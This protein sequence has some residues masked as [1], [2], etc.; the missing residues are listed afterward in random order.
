MS[1]DND[2]KRDLAEIAAHKLRE[3]RITKRGFLQAMAALGVIPMAGLGGRAMAAPSEL[4]I[5]NWGGTAADVIKEVLGDTYKE[6]TGID[7]VIDG[8]GPSAGRIRAMV[9]S[10]AVVWDVCDSG[11]GSAIILG[12][13]GVTEPMNYDIID[14]TKMMEGTDWE[15]G[16]GNY[17]YSYVLAYNP[18][19]SEGG[20]PTSWA[21]VFDTKNFPGMRTFR[22]AVRGMLECATMAQG[23]PLAEVYDVLSTEDGIDAAIEQFRKIRENVIVWGSGSESQNLFL[24]EEVVMGNI[25][26]TR[27][28][29]LK[30]EMDEGTFAVS[31]DGGV[32]SPGTWV[33]PKGNPAGAEEAMKFIAFAQDPALQVK[34]FELIGSAPI[35]PAAAPLVP[36]SMS[37]WNPTSPENVATQILYNDEWYAANQIAAE[38][39]YVNALIN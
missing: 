13:A 39:K 37:R 2:F 14:R 28:H 4:V 27:A 38:E 8:S 25:W 19:L 15:Y 20:V 3:G 17:V 34:W 6:A 22:K 31:F 5:V 23:V 36:E 11:P 32:M 7:V 21:D 16:A 26:S 10:G 9:E 24:Q 18:K 1:H 30:D 12:E 35:N 29:L 33:V